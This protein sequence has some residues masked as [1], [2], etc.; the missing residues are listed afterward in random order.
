MTA[1]EWEKA[2]ALQELDI[3]GTDLPQAAILDCIT[4][5]PALVWLS[6]GQLD[7]MNDT[8]ITQVRTEACHKMIDCYLLF[9][10]DG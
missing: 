5:I 10:V 6:A 4:R 1:V 2:G 7:G 9:S 8:V 3:T